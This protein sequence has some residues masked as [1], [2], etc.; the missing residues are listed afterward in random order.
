MPNPKPPAPTSILDLAYERA[1]GNLDESFVKDSR[2]EGDVEF[3]CRCSN[4]AGTRF[5]MACLIAKLFNPSLDI[6]KPYTEIGSEGIYSGRHY[7]ETYIRPVA[8]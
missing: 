8:R 1:S 3:V 5:L 6:R 2:I 7:D 4:L